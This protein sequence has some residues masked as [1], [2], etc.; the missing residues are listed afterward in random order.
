M[1]DEG[2]KVKKATAKRKGQ[3]PAAEGNGP[4][5]KRVTVKLKGGK[6]NVLKKATGKKAAAKGAASKRK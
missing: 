2:E 1:A 5:K 3:D 4:K 6:A